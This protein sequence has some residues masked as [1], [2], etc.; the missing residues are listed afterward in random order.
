MQKVDMS[1]AESQEVMSLTLG[2]LKSL[3]NDS[4][5]DQFWQRIRGSSEELDVEKPTLPCCHVYPLS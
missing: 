4:S 1:A 5:Y 3:C 2:T